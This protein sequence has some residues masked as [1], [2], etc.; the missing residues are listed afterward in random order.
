[1][2]PLPSHLLL[3]SVDAWLDPLV[4]L[5]LLVELAVLGRGI[6]TREPTDIVLA[7]IAVP[8]LFFSL[9]AVV[10]SGNP[11]GVIWGGLFSAAAGGILTFLVVSDIVLRASLLTRTAD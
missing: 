11:S 10:E 8:C 6:Y 7:T 1:M 5:P 2:V 3:L 4:V 9:W